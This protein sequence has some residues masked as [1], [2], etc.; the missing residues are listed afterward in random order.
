[1][2]STVMSTVLTVQAISIG[3]ESVMSTVTSTV[4]EQSTRGSPVA[5]L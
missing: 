4:V 5:V 1:M 2:M 3:D